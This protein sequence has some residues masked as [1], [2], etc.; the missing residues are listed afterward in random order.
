MLNRLS[1]GLLVL[2]PLSFFGQNTATQFANLTI[3]INSD[4]AKSV[5]VKASQNTSYSSYQDDL[6]YI[7]IPT[8]SK[9]FTAAEIIANQNIDLPFKIQVRP[10]Q[11]NPDSFQLQAAVLIQRFNIVGF[12]SPFFFNAQFYPLQL[13][14]AT[15]NSLY[16]YSRILH[17]SNA[18]KLW[19]QGQTV[20]GSSSTP[21]TTIAFLIAN[22]YKNYNILESAT[23]TTALHS[24]NYTLSVPK[25][26]ID[27]LAGQIAGT[28]FFQIYLTLTPYQVP[29][30]SS[31]VSFLK[32]TNVFLNTLYQQTFSYSA[33][34]PE[35]VLVNR[36]FLLNEIQ[37]VNTAIAL[38]N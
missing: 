13:G 8:V 1:I 14:A 10:V 34:V 24:V 2:L 7:L 28:Y 38:L 4:T 6:A 29:V 23:G 26:A 16:A 37:E 27:Y 25:A 32:N 5:T 18:V 15:A 35:Q 21:Q 12:L 11:T 33:P 22:S 17:L 31:T 20:I 9:T 19:Y 3:T 36:E 30:N